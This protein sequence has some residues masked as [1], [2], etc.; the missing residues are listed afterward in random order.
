VQNCL[1]KFKVVGIIDRD[2]SYGSPYSG[3]ILYNEFRSALYDLPTCP[4]VHGF[5]CGLG[6][7]E[8][9]IG[10][11]TEMMDMMLETAKSGKV[12]RQVAWIGVRE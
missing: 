5:I 8:V 2:Y 9:T 7:R 1:K 11:V 6:G 10:G 4:K 12:D 3:G